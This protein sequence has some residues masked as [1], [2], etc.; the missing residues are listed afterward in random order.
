MRGMTDSWF[1]LILQDAAIVGVIGGNHRY[2]EVAALASSEPVIEAATPDSASSVAD[3]VT[4]IQ[5][6][7]PGGWNI[8][9]GDGAD[10]GV[11]D[12]EDDRVPVHRAVERFLPSSRAIK[13]ISIG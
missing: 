10:I 8:T 1:G 4:G 7:L 9:T 2:A 3:L 12:P 13:P 11:T 5:R 6:A